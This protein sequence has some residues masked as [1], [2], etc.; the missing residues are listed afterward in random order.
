MH[1]F[2]IFCFTLVVSHFCFECFELYWLRAHAVFSSRTAPGTTQVRQARAEPGARGP[3]IALSSARAVE[4]R[5]G[6]AG[7]GNK[8]RAQKTLFLLRQKEE[9]LQYALVALSDK[10]EEQRQVV[11]CVSACNACLLTTHVQIMDYCAR[12]QPHRLLNE[13]RRERELE[14]DQV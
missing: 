14:E 3:K 5:R 1:A 13:K 4:S 11:H 2:L 7:V 6:A 8:T 9:E 12:A 10:L